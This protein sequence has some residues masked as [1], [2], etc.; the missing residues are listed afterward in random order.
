[1]VVWAPVNDV[2]LSEWWH[3]QYVGFTSL[4]G[5]TTGQKCTYPEKKIVG[6]SL[7][8][9]CLLLNALDFWPQCLT[10]QTA[11]FPLIL[12]KKHTQKPMKLTF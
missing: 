4:A 10:I 8:I 2:M 1:M 3:V 11:L 6:F 5:H 7:E 9:K 12:C